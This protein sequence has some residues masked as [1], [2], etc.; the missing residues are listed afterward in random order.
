MTSSQFCHSSSLQ[1]FLESRQIQN[2]RYALN[3]TFVN[4]KKFLLK[5]VKRTTKSVVVLSSI[6]QYIVFH[7][8]DVNG[9]KN[10]HPSKWQSNWISASVKRFHHR[11]NFIILKMYVRGVVADCIIVFVQGVPNK[12]TTDFSYQVRTLLN[13][14]TLLTWWRGQG[15]SLKL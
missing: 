5:L 14:E 15:S 7:S 9:T 6:A 13:T 2:K 4:I 1:F 10:P 11:L 12:L 3:P 8:T